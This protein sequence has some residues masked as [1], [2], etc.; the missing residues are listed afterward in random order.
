MRRDRAM[1]ALLFLFPLIQLLVL[2]HVISADV[3]NIDTVV[4]DLDKTALS[5][6]IVERITHSGYFN[7]RYSETSQNALAEYLDRNR[8]M[9][10]VVIPRNLSRDVA[11]GI[12]ARIQVLADGQDSKTAN[13]A[14]GYLGGIL[15]NFLFETVT[16][17]MQS[18][19]EPPDIHFVVP[20]V[21]V[22]FNPD[23][24]SKDFMIPGIMVFLL[25]MVGSLISALG[26]I[27]EREIGTLDQLMVSPLRKHELLIG[28]IVSY[29]VIGV[30][31]LSLA[32]VFARLYYRIPIEGSLSL[33]AIFVMVYLFTT[34]GLGLFVSAVS[35][36]QQQS[37]FMTFF[38]IVFFM[39]MSGFIFPI[40]NMPTIMRIL[41]YLSPMRYMLIVV[42][43]IFIKGTTFPYLIEQG[44]AM[45][46][47]G[48]VIFTVAL[49]KFRRRMG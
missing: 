12:P 25:T 48:A 5:R 44:V 38:L 49:A 28:K 27:R 7:V 41:S 42:R 13:V 40:E 35:H 21:T 10:A 8:A 36:T 29:A 37:M 18:L 22:L 15:E 26:L 45:V 47:F 32:L 2:G 31:E 24:T 46:I 39:I 9:V 3:K 34:L 14:L 16:I 11:G 17:E 33:F 19:S 43:E 6:D 30:I 20:S 23:L 4:C 1:M